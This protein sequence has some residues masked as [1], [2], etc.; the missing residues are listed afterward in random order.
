[1]SRPLLEALLANH[2]E[3]DPREA[4][5]RILRGDVLVDGERLTKPGFAVD[6][7]AVIVLKPRPRYVSRAGE[8]LAGAL[9]QLELEVSGRVFVDAGCSTG[10]F[11]DCLLTRGARAVH[12]VDVGRGQLAWKLRTDPRVHVREGTN[13]M[14]LS[15][16]TLDPPADAAVCDLSFR[17]VLGAVSHLLG[18]VR[19]GWV[20]ALVK[21][22]FE[23]DGSP[24]EFD[25]VV[26]DAARIERILGRVREGLEREGLTVA[27]V[28][29]SVLPGRRGNREC[30]YLIRR[31][32]GTA[33]CLA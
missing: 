9:D 26:R 7:E 30:F 17:S 31:V 3:L 13:V 20:L 4:R 22:Q 27:G 32:S 33:Q 19:E 6:P 15:A 21:P 16:A 29:P 8:K 14:S 2:P 11:T 25:G 1:M 12:A 28:A 23:W 18:L 24:E 10:G 5:G